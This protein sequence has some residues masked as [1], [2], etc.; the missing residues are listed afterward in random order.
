G[1]WKREKG[2]KARGRVTFSFCLVVFASCLLLAGGCRNC[3]LVEAEL[4][5]RDVDLR[6]VR[7]DLARV[8]AQNE[9]LVRELTSVRHGAASTISPELASQTYTLKQ[10]TLDRGTGGL[11]ED[12]IP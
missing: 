6:D 11:D 1:K 5:S 8:E 7:A 2:M 3:D 10:I 9:A 4:R 12:N